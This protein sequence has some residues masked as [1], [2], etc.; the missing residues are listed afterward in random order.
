MALVKQPQILL[1]DEMTSSLDVESER[2]ILNTIERICLKKQLTVI[3]VTHRKTFIKDHFRV[4]NLERGQ[5]QL[6]THYHELQ[7]AK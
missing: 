6:D 3:S 4:I 2:K 7:L 5:I 1:L